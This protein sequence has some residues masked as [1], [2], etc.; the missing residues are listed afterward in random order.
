M[1]LFMVRRI[2]LALVTFGL[3]FGLAIIISSVSDKTVPQEGSRTTTQVIKTPG[4]LECYH[5]ILPGDAGGPGGNPLWTPTGF[6][7]AYEN[8]PRISPSV[9]REPNHVY[10][11]SQPGASD[12]IV[13]LTYDRGY[14]YK[15]RDQVGESFRGIAP[16][17]QSSVP[18]GVKSKYAPFAE[19]V[20]APDS[21][22]P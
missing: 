20:V 21:C 18:A 14:L 1:E 2:A 17:V 11:L 9:L 10:I 7:V 19:Y 6:P 15:V 3:G 8:E 12:Q 13:L 5:E 16:V 22:L 4:I